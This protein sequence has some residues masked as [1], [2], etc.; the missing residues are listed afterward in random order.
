MAKIDLEEVEQLL[1]R[2][3]VPEATVVKVLTDAA[4][5]LKEEKEERQK[6]KVPGEKF[7][8]VVVIS[9]PENKIP[10]DVEFTAFVVKHRMDVDLATIPEK[11]Q[12]VA[13]DS[14]STKKNSKNPVRTVGELFHWVKRRFWKSYAIYGI[15]KDPVRVFL[16]SNQL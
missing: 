14:N 11:L 13:R 6:E 7:G 10:R 16:S 1:L 12:L 8:H 9:D 3:N 5:I 15:T 2:N 4:A